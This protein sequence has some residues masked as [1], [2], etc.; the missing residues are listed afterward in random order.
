MKRLF[1]L[2]FVI[3][4]LAA[5][6]TFACSCVDYQINRRAFRDAKSVFIGT[7]IDSWLMGQDA[8]DESR[9]SSIF[10]MQVKF[11]VEKSWKGIK[12]SEI[13]ITSDSDLTVSIPCGFRFLKG[14]KYLVYAYGGKLEAATMCARDI[15]PLEDDDFTRK[16]LKQLN[17]FWFRTYSRFNPF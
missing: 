15:T 11:K 1:L 9:E 13:I 8:D 2:A 4:I 5:P 10:G 17:S 7:P 3:Y 6:A 16:R 12:S 14:K